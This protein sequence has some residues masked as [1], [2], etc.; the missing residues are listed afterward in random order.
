ML[1]RGDATTRHIVQA[2]GSSSTQ[3]GND[4]VAKTC[5]KHSPTVYDSYQ[6]VY[7]DPNVDV[8]YIG[9]PHVFHCENTVEAI[10][11][12]KHVVCEKPIA[13]NARDTERMQAAAKAKGVYLLEGQLYF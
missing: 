3:K 6:G 8:V 7:N 9:T 12:G 11:A 13:M 4:F 5:P 10:A 1:D 2:V